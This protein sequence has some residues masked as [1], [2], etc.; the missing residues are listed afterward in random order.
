MAYIYSSV[1]SLE[2]TAKVGTK[3]C[4]VLV[5]HYANAP[6]TSQWTEGAKVKGNTTIVKGTAIATF[7]G[8]VYPNNSTG[9]HAA[10]YIS[11]DETGIWVM[12]QW[13]D[14]DSKPTV[15]KRRLRFK[16]ANADG[17]YKDPSN[18]GDAFSII[19]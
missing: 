10:L 4:V 19:E 14:D 12:D 6:R 15:S 3:H 8:G 2:G 5:Q 11:Q 1:D 13:K 16:G 9:N 18:N 7:V 17:S